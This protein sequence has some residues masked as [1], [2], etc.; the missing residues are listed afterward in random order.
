MW[1]SATLVINAE[2]LPA[3]IGPYLGVARHRHATL[4][5]ARRYMT[6]RHGAGL[7]PTWQ[8]H[9]VVGAPVVVFHSDGVVRGKPHLLAH[10]PLL[11]INA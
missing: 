8:P 4:A 2:D 1:P 11:A 3:P 10:R 5:I 7:G 9:E 6:R